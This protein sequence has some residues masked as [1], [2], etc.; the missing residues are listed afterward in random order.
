MRFLAVGRV[1]RCMAIDR[2]FEASAIRCGDCPVSLDDIAQESESTSA[3]ASPRTPVLEHPPFRLPHLRPVTAALRGVCVSI[4]RHRG[5]RSGRIRLSTENFVHIQKNSGVCQLLERRR[6][7]PR[8]AHP[9]ADT[10]ASR[11]VLDP[12]SYGAS[13]R[14][15]RSYSGTE[16]CVLERSLRRPTAR[17]TLIQRHSGVPERPIQRHRGVSFPFLRTRR[18]ETGGDTAAIRF[19]T[20]TSHPSR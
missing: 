18:N 19:R 2:R 16:G 10:A 15:T 3:I 20:F 14:E 12:T 9:L 17:D 5:V 11:G 4:Q 8:L 13:L 7:R 1:F 6:R